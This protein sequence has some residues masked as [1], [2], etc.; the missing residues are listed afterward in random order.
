MSIAFL[1]LQGSGG[2]AIP[3]FRQQTPTQ[4]AVHSP[5]DSMRLKKYE[6]GWRF[7]NG[8]HWSFV[9]EEGEPLVTANYCRTVVNKKASWLVGKGMIVDVPQAVR[10]ITK[11]VIEKVWK[12][13]DEDQKL[14]S[15]AIMGGVTGDVCILVGYQP[16]TPVEQ[17]LNPY[18]QGRIRIRLLGSHQCFPQ[19]NPLNME[20]L[21][22]L[23][24][25][26]EVPVYQP[27]PQDIRKPATMNGM[28]VVQKRRYI[29]DIYPDR[30]VRGWEDQEK[31][32]IPND[33]GEIPFVH[34][35]N[36]IFPGEYWGKSDLDD[37][38][39]IQREFNEKL[40]DISDIVNYHASPV[41]IITGAKAKQLEK[42]PKSLWSGLPAD[43]KVYNLQLA[44]DLAVS[45]KYLEFV[46]QLILDISNVPEGAFG[47]IQSI[48]NTSA[49]ALQVQFQPLVEV[50][51]RKQTNYVAGLQKVNYFILRYDQLMHKKVYPVDLCKNCGGRIVSFKITGQ[52]GVERIKRKCYM[53][54]P[55]TLDFMK[56]DDVKVS[57]TIEHSFGNEVRK[58]PYGLV[59]DRWGKKHP[60]YWDP[61][62]MVDKQ[63]EAQLNK[64]HA[65]K[66]QEEAKA[67]LQQQGEDEHQRNLETIQAK[68]PPAVPGKK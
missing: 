19:W 53:V 63:E 51:Q 39:D 28:G 5:V 65:E 13:N 34:I 29:E 8:I 41:T 57:V 27:V 9:R 35:P 38:I 43:A 1:S 16:P 48:S 44:G 58:M 52:D 31:E 60:S 17:R 3:F 33:L 50:T 4:M 20:E 42:G 11:P 64:E 6:E 14:L 15:M 56:P 62:P 10:S 36:E 21:A 66:K 26:T 47:R 46:R 2:T 25:V 68:Q 54:D 37:I 7:Y 18:A 45:Y 40:T 24:I 61:E 49:A 22:M 55:Q 67:D 30:I 59:K 12:D 23:R 32:N